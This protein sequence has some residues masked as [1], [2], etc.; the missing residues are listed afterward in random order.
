MQTSPMSYSDD[1]AGLLRALA[2][3][4]LVVVPGVD[5]FTAMIMSE[6]SLQL[7]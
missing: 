4:L 3:A 2:F 6:A 1:H 5:H 7:L